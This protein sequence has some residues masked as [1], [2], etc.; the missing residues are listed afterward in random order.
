[1]AKKKAKKKKK[2]VKAAPP[3]KKRTSA[4]RELV[5]FRKKQDAELSRLS[6]SIV[7]FRDIREKANQCLTE[8]LDRVR[9]L[10]QE[11]LSSKRAL[12]AYRS[13]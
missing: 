9:E 3:K 4:E 2:P 7:E 13:K 11:I 5:A 6:K 1:M 10:Q 12:K 8:D